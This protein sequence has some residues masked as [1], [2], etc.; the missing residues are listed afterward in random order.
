MKRRLCIGISNSSP[1]WKLILDQIGAHYEELSYQTALIKSYSCIILTS[2]INKG[3]HHLVL[4]YLDSGGCV[5][6][7]NGQNF[8]DSKNISNEYRKHLFNNNSIFSESYLDI[9]DQVSTIDQNGFFDQAISIKKKEQG[10]L[11]FWGLPIDRLMSNSKFLRKQFLDSD[12]LFP[13]E[14]VAQVSK[15]K[16][17]RIIEELLIHIHQELS[18]PFIRKNYFSSDSSSSFLFRIDTD[19]S[20]KA[21]IKRLYALADKHKI[22]MTWFLH[23][24]AHEQWLSEFKGMKNQEIAVHGY[25]HGTSSSYQKNG[26]NIRAAMDLLSESDVSFSGYCAPYGIWNS[27]LAQLMDEYNFEYASE[28]SLNYDD[29]PFFPISQ[30]TPYA[31]LQIPIHPIC[32]GSFLRKRASVQQMKSYF[33]SY[34]EYQIAIGEP[35]VLYH[36]PMQGHEQ[37]LEHI[38]EYINQLNIPS[39]SFSEFSSFWKMRNESLFEAFWENDVIEIR[40]DSNKEL[41][42]NIY[43]G[44][45]KGM[46]SNSKNTYRLSEI[47]LET[48]TEV[49]LISLSVI[50][51]LLH[52]NLKLRKWSVLDWYRRER[53]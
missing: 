32:I 5:I 1:S 39:V 48:V 23:V 10:L 40:S 16:I 45:K 9:F 22:S 35:I 26:D 29:L 8:F 4:D 2:K 43:W 27:G 51:K 37:V 46:V 44:S 17:R 24:Q 36:H 6:D 41:T 11:C 52:R 30:N 28:F 50:R 49:P 18:L 47:T 33:Q 25:K 38:F 53:L 42:Y 31:H 19:Y 13:N 20:N 3:E 7:T 21:T 12:R 14:I 15:G 34:I